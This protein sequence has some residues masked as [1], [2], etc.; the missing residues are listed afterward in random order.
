MPAHRA[1]P[2]KPIVSGASGRCSQI[3]ALVI[4]MVGLTIFW[5]N[6]ATAQSPN[7]ISVA[8]LSFRGTEFARTTW[9]ETFTHLEKTL[10]E[11]NF[12]LQALSLSDLTEQAEEFDFIITNPGH[13]FQL[14]KRIGASRLVSARVLSSDDQTR[15]LGSVIVVPAQSN[16]QTFEDLKN[17]M[18]GVVS[19]DAFGG[20]LVARYAI[21]QALGRRLPLKTKVVG[22]PHQTVLRAVQDGTV[23]AG[24]IR[25]CLLESLDAAGELDQT[26]FRILGEKKTP[27]FS[28]R[29][30]TD[31]FPGWAFMKNPK[32]RSET[33]TRVTQALL[34]MPKPKKSDPW[35]GNDGWIA[36]VSYA[37]VDAVYRN[38]ELYPYSHDLQTILTNW[39]KENL[40]WMALALVLLAAFLLHVGHVELLVLRREKQLQEASQRNSLLESELAHAD[41]VSSMN[42]LAG[43]L[44]HDLKQ[45]LAAI[46]TFAHSLL[47]R[48][49]RGTATDEIVEQQL[50]R[51]SAQANRASEFISSMR[52][53]L[54]K[55]P[56][57]NNE[58]D[59][60]LLI[61]EVIMLM[62][63]YAQRQQCQLL[64]HRPDHPIHLV[65]DD[66]QLRQVAVALIQNAVDASW[67]QDL[68]IS[69]QQAAKKI[70]IHLDDKHE[71][72]RL[73]ISDHGT[74]LDE[75]IKDKIFDPFFSTKG[76]LGLGLATAASIVDNHD[77][78]LTL[79][80]GENGGTVATMRLPLTNQTLQT[81]KA[82]P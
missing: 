48:H 9:S 1:L 5:C 70:E 74:G 29:V 66:V 59:L 40:F 16:I 42:I 11:I 43:S 76:G 60:R 37:A 80:P 13:S 79:S 54:I 32:V 33:A 4:L 34:A 56:T 25:A 75:T 30:S 69:D 31:L 78:Q 44:A 52:N 81:G 12:S 57:S 46:S 65:C 63:G 14:E 3:Y 36:P 7:S 50:T 82:E 45:P 35:L 26:I 6:L 77:G 24:I 22:F 8:V 23:E 49:K 15:A 58:Q 2:I 53:F 73:D 61:D 21:D 47:L 67:A 62:K 68:Q 19:E 20:H 55:Q 28:C 27:R 72:I 64:W 17:R 51:I 39:I 41:R 71:Q 10:P 18:V 38:L